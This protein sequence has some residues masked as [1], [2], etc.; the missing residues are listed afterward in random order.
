MKSGKRN[1]V[2]VAVAIVYKNAVNLRMYKLTF[3]SSMLSLLKYL[4]NV[5]TKFV[6]NIFISY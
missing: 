1:F 2:A 6:S 3:N 5:I 4:K